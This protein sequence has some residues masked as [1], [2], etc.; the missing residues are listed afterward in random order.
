MYGLFA[1]GNANDLESLQ[2]HSL[3]QAFR[4]DF[5]PGDAMVAWYLL[6]SHVRVSVCLLQ[7]RYVLKRLHIGSRRQRWTISQGLCIFMMHK[8]F[9]KFQWSLPQ[10]PNGSVKCRWGRKNCILWLIHKSQAQMLYLQK[11]VSIHHIDSHPWQCAGGRIHG[12]VNI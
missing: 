1:R 6:S 10:R 4:C 3:L 12:V 2:G 7:A 8:I 11:L 9:T 5:C